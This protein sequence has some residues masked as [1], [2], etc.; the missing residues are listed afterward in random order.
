MKKAIVTGASGFVGRWLVNRLIE[1]SVQVTAIELEGAAG[2]ALLPKSDLL[3]VVF[4]KSED[5]PNLH[6]MIQGHEFDVFYNLAWVGAGGPK[7]ADY[8]IQ[9]N[10]VKLCLD[11]YMSA[12]KLGCKKFVAIGTI[13]QF[14]AELSIESN[15]V[16]E[17]FIYA[18]SKSFCERLL[19]IQEDGV[20]CKV[21]WTTLTGLYG[22]GDSTPN[23]INYTIKSLL[24]GASPT[25]GPAAQPFDF[26]HISDCVEALYLIGFSETQEKSFLIGSG[27]PRPLKD[28]L[29]EIG[30]IV[31]PDV[32]MGIGAR[33]DDGTVYKTEWFDTSALQKETGFAPKFSFSEGIRLTAD[34]QRSL[35]EEGKKNGYH[36]I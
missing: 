29:V 23:L 32:A 19:R 26:I 4:C 34:W 30:T 6:E 27:Q 36:T 18:L 17:N 12:Q 1:R 8:T 20:D 10:N 24:G 25:Y 16:S 21:V 7:R 11:Y 28:F 2:L 3:T 14:M 33:P 5:A 13:G 9:L 35:Q 22:V 15:I 31:A